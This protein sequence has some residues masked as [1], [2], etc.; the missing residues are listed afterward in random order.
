MKTT[1]LLLSLMLLWTVIVACKNDTADPVDDGAKRAMKENNGLVGK[2]KIVEYLA[3]PGDGS[4]TYQAVTDDVAHIIEFK[5]NGEFVEKK[6]QGQSSVPLF[7]A[8]KVL[9]DK[10]I[11]LIPIDKTAP[12]H[13]WYY[14]DLST[15]KLTLGYGCIEAC[16]GKY[17][18][19]E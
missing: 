8:Y 19:V 12:S 9:D 4:G 2:W 3:D 13:I 14:S 11:E 1:R 18:A 10:R 17:I 5:E 16:S 15:S 6:A 7:N